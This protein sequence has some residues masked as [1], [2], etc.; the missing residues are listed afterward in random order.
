MD[1]DVTFT[2]AVISFLTGVKLPFMINIVD[3][4]IRLAV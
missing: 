3:V 2:A 1:L 4:S